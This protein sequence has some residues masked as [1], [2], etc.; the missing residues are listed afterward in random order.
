VYRSVTVADQVISGD[1]KETVAY[2]MLVGI[3]HAQ[4]KTAVLSSLPV[5]KAD[6]A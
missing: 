5:V 4:G 1:S 6:E 2:A 3:A